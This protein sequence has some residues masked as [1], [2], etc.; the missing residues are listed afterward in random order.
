MATRKQIIDAL[1]RKMAQQAGK[2]IEEPG[3]WHPD[4]WIARTSFYDPKH[5][6]RYGSFYREKAERFYD[7]WMLVQMMSDAKE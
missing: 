5:E 4:D 1:A 6:D 7:R 3:S 2:E